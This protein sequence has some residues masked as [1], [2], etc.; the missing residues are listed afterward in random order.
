[1][2]KK[3]LFISLLTLLFVGLLVFSFDLLPASKT[4]QV[5]IDGSPVAYEKKQE[6]QIEDIS[7]VTNFY[8][9]T[10]PDGEQAD[11]KLTVREF[12]NS[13]KMLY[14]EAQSKDYLKPIELNLPLS[15]QADLKFSEDSTI[16]ELYSYRKP[17]TVVDPL[18]TT[19]QYIENKD[20]SALLGT[21]VYFNDMSYTYENGKKSNVVEL[22]REAVGAFRNQDEWEI[23]IQFEPGETQFFYLADGI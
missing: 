2:K 13:D 7:E 19:L 16:P 4:L 15:G 18:S 20:N 12:P 17:R 14:I 21:A 1:M 8:T 23:I 6:Q 11:L 10:Q 3:I 22:Q 9:L 5:S